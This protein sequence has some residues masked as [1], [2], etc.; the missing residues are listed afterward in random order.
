MISGIGQGVIPVAALDL[1]CCW[2]RSCVLVPVFVVPVFLVAPKFVAV[3][4]F[5][6]V[7]VM[8][9]VLV[10]TVTRCPGWCRRQAQH[11]RPVPASSCGTAS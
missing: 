8:T 1:R 11:E 7:P 6:V 5:L 10:V 4:Y 3:R 2:C 9:V